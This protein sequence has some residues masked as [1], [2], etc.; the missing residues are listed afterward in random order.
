MEEGVDRL[1]VALSQGARQEEV[2]NNL[3]GGLEEGEDLQMLG[4]GHW[5]EA[6]H[7]VGVGQMAVVVH[8]E[9]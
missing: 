1:L 7:W 3:G 8:L 5:V 4:D 2:Q 6:D 9:A